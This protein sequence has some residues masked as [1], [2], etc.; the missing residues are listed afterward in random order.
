MAKKESKLKTKE[1]VETTGGLEVITL[2]NQFYRD[3]F[4]RIVTL[5]LLLLLLNAALIGV[6]F[7]IYKT[8]PTPKYFAT[9]ADGKI[10]KLPPLSSPVL[11]LNQLLTWTVEAATAAYTFDFVNYQSQLQG[12]RDYFTATGHANYLKALESTNNLNAVRAKKLVVSAVPTGTPI[13]LQ[14]GPVKKGRY[15][16]RY[17]WQVQLPMR[18]SYQSANEV[19]NQNIV[20]TM[21]VTRIS[22]LQ[23]DRG[24]G[25]AQLV[26]SEK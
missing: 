2:R 6:C 23:S 5:M 13:V 20:V 16:G 26:V 1:E 21:L 10:I 12:L 14:E 17:A 19:I 7:Y 11:N 3:N 8:R 22:T 15:Q 24:V 18:V 25:I 4:R 9:T